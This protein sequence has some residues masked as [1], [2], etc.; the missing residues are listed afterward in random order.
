MELNR[1][2]LADKP[3]IVVPNHMLEQFAREVLQLYPQAKLLVAQ[4]E[5][6]HADR[7]RLF[8][9][10]C[11]TG[12]WDAVIISLRFERIPVAQRRAARPG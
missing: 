3:A 10:R 8:V 7:R 9:A 2:G 11:A 12:D 6:L 4:Q 5:H 1:L